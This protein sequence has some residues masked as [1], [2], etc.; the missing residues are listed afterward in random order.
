MRLLIA[1]F[2]LALCGCTQHQCDKW[3]CW[4]PGMFAAERD[5]VC[6]VLEM[7]RQQ[8]EVNDPCR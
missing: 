7:Q 1:L 5:E 6:R 2:I 3:G 4:D 8:R